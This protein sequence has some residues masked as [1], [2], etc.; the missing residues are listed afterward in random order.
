MF[1]LRL[2]FLVAGR[3]PILH[4]ILALARLAPTRI[5]SVRDDVANPFFA[6]VLPV[7]VEPWGVGKAHLG[8][9][10]RPAHAAHDDG[11]YPDG[12][13]S[14]HG[15]S[16]QTE[17]CRGPAPHAPDLDLVRPRDHRNLLGVAV[18]CS[19]VG[20]SFFALAETLLCLVAGRHHALRVVVA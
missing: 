14:P 13:I 17:V 11:T 19:G 1:G 16:T 20:P 18:L 15:T 3:E 4:W 10:A 12:P 7:A 6:R 2:C 8:S 5:S 9:P